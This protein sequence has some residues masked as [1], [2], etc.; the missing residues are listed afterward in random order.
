MEMTVKI[1][2]QR[3]CSHLVFMQQRDRWINRERE[4]KERIL[5]CITVRKLITV[6]LELHLFHCLSDS[7]AKEARRH[8]FPFV[9]LTRLHKQRVMAD[10]PVLPATSCREAGLRKKGRGGPVW[11]RLKTRGSSLMTAAFTDCQHIAV[12]Q[13]LL[14]EPPEPVAATWE[15]VT[16]VG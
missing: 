13:P 6:M 3:L 16:D 5:H 15:V 1:W 14:M 9:I 7:V 12:Y 4:E 2:H 11:Q 8:L 10:G